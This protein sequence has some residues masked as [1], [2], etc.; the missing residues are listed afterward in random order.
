MEDDIFMRFAINTDVGDDG[1]DVL[2]AWQSRRIGSGETRFGHG[3]DA[4]DSLCNK[5]ASWSGSTQ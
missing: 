4:R 3:S 1:L 5:S 2:R